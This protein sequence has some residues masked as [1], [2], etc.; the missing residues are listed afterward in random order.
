L[1]ITNASAKAQT[2]RDWIDPLGE[3]YNDILNWSGI[4]VPNTISETANSSIAGTYD[5]TLNSGVTTVVSACL[6]SMET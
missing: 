6:F 1:A 5:V 2:V 3:N 4:N